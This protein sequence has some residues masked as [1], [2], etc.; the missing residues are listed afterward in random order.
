MAP[1]RLGQRLVKVI[2]KTKAIKFLTTVLQTSPVTINVS[3][4]Y[5][6]NTREMCFVVMTR[7]VVWARAALARIDGCEIIH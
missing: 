2:S 6:W 5:V 1:D 4:L 7:C 3:G